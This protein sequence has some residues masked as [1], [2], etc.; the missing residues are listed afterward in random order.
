MF[1][2]CTGAAGTDEWWSK[3]LEWLLWVGSGH[4]AATAPVDPVRLDAAPVN[5]RFR[6]GADIRLLRVSDR[7]ERKRPLRVFIGRWR[8]LATRLQPRTAWQAYDH[9]VHK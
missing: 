5:D 7:C 4:H 1:A 6:L 2:C 8:A 9:F 3:V